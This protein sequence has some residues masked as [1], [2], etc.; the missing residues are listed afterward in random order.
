MDLSSDKTLQPGYFSC[1]KTEMPNF[2][3]I[4]SYDNFINHQGVIR[5]D[6]TQI[7]RLF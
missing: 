2:I 1:V 7:K 3:V 6:G 5:D 4:M